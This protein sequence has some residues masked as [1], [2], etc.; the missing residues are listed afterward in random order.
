MSKLCQQENMERMHLQDF[1]DKY[2]LVMHCRVSDWITQPLKEGAQIFCTS[3]IL[4]VVTRT[5][6]RLKFGY[7]Q[8]IC[9]DS[10]PQYSIN[11]KSFLVF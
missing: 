6:M 4:A 5:G 7:S 11:F 1:R 3:P 2:L 8:S 9:D 10:A